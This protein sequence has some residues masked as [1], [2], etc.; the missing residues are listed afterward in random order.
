MDRVIQAYC[1]VAR[2]GFDC[3]V[4]SL[5][6]SVGFSEDA[7]VQF[8]SKAPALGEEREIAKGRRL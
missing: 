8:I 2:V 6:R 3:V 4:D 1:K 5:R 7:I